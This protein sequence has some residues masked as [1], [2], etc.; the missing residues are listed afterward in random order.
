[1]A[2]EATNAPD[3]QPQPRCEYGKTLFFEGECQ[4]TGEV[5]SDGSLLC[6][7]HAELS[8][9]E[10][11]EATLLGRVFDMDKWL[12]QPR[13]RI[14]NIHWRRELRQRDEAVEQLRFNHTQIEAHREA[15]G[16]R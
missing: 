8:R 12:D 3:A 9:L 13:N 1:M 16:Q 7:P 14:D 6:A 15:N 10:G 4:S 11:R 5:R 2:M